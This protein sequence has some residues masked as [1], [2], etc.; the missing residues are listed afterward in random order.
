[1]KSLPRVLFMLIIASLLLSACNL[2]TSKTTEPSADANLQLTVAAQTVSALITERAQLTAAAVTQL[3]ATAV[4]T[5]AIPP[6]L[7]PTAVN[8]LPMPTS[9]PIPPMPTSTRIPSP[10]NRGEFVADITIPDNTAI[11]PGANFTKTWRLSNTGSCIWTTGYKAIFDTGNAMGAPASVAL[12]KDIRPGDVVDISVDM[13]APATGGT[14][15]GNWKLQDKDGNKFG[16]GDAASE[17][18]WVKILVNITPAPFAV[19]TI[20]MAAS[21]ATYTGV[22]PVTITFT[23]GIKTTGAGTVTYYWEFSDGTKQPEQTL[24]FTDASQKTVTTTWTVGAPGQTVNGYAKIYVNNP[25][26]QYFSAANFTVTCN[27]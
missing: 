2:P 6:T 26:H 25:N 17:P 15:Q 23:G 24:V 18:F 12:T 5:T 1:M 22:C 4:P 27:P 3:P 14:Y 21:P 19:S 8:T 7:A 11:K 13:V 9:T 10:C 16:L 20:A